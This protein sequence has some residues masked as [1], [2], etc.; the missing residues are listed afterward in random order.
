MQGDVLAA[1]AGNDKGAPTVATNTKFILPWD[2]RKPVKGRMISDGSGM[3][4]DSIAA[5]AQRPM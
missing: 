5:N 3:H 1:A 4:A 2:T